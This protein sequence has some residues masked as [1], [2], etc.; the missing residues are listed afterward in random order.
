MTERTRWDAIAEELAESTEDPARKPLPKV[1]LSVAGQATFDEARR[2]SLPTSMTVMVTMDGAVTGEV[3]KASWSA[4]QSYDEEHFRAYGVGAVGPLRV[5]GT[6][7][8]A[9]IGGIE[10]GRAL[11]ISV[12]NGDDEIHI[13][14]HVTSVRR[15]LDP[16][17]GTAAP[18]TVDFVGTL[19]S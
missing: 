12:L 7:N 2:R 14:A 8:M 10:A 6:L 9:T 4:E 5:S 15:R 18:V 11:M 19:V 3:L 16:R 17:S 13:A 1:V